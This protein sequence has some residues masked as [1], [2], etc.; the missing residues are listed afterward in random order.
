MSGPRTAWIFLTR[1]P[2]GDDPSGDFASAV[3]WFPVIGA[4]IGA[5]TAAAW[6]LTH[7]LFPPLPAAALTVCAAALLTGAFHHDGLADMADAFGGGWTREQRFEILKDSRHGTYGVMAIVGAVVT[8][9]AALA[10]LG[11][12]QGAAAVVA[13]HTLGRA[14]AIV[15][16][17]VVPAARDDGLA[18]TAGARPAIAPIATGCAAAILLTAIALG[19]WTLVAIAAVT[20]TT[21]ACAWL[22]WRKIGGLTG[23]VL[24]AIEQLGETAVLL[25][26]AALVRRDVAFPWWR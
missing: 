9:V 13:A 26:V 8:Q 17:G 24:G 21:A 22:A 1:V 11:V 19:G 25:A 20:A 5:F 3:P 23:D 14:G 10:T 4:A 7:A 2:A 18:A 6:T 16:M 12:A 15:A